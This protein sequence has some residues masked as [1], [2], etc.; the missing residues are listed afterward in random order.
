MF[1]DLK[2]EPFK[3][4]IDGEPS[5]EQVLQGLHDETQPYWQA[6]DVRR[7]AYW[8][9]FAGAFGHTYGDNS[10]MQF[11]Q[12]KSK[13]GAF[14]VKDTWKEA[15]HHPGSG[16]MKHMKDLMES[17]DYQSGKASDSLVIGGQG[18]RYERKSV[19]AGKNYLFCYDYAGTPFTLDLSP[20]RELT[21]KAY[22][23]EPE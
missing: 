4:T 21:M 5:Y 7:Y 19:F 14:G 9:V 12:D 18:E 3:P 8:A 13:K 10:I 2:L 20:Y 6:R 11:Y 23:F 16:Q 22:W 17:V 15:L 1:R